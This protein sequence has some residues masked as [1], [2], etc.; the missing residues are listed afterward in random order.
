MDSLRKLAFGLDLPHP[1]V[2]HLVGEG[3]AL[4]GWQSSG[5]ICGSGASIDW[6]ARVELMV[7]VVVGCHIH[8]YI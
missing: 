7:V 5:P 4:I 8:T 3:G 1:L 2:A 6:L